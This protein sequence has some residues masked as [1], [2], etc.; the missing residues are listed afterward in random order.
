M[1][2]AAKKEVATSQKTDGN[3]HDTNSKK[4]TVSVFDTTLHA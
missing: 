2:S 3:K 1:A 4:A